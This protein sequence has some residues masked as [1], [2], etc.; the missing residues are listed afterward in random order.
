MCIWKDEN[1]WK[2][3]RVGPFKKQWKRDENLGRAEGERLKTSRGCRSGKPGGNAVLFE[4][5]NRWSENR[6]K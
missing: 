6:Q 5:R 3:A 4:S 1:K 2:E